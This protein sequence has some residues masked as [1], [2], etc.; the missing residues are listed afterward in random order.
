MAVLGADELRIAEFGE[1][2]ADL[3]D[4]VALAQQVDV[5]LGRAATT[6]EMADGC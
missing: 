3:R 6:L 2:T 5:P 1:V 4:P